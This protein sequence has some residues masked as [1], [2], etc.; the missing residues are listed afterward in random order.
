MRRKLDRRQFLET[1]GLTGLAALGGIACNRPGNPG[2]AASQA[3]PADSPARIAAGGPRAGLC[4][5]AFQERPLD[6]VI[7]LAAQAGF[8]GIEP[9]G[10]PDHLPLDTPDERVIAVREKVEGLGM[11][12]AHYGSYVRL[13]EQLDPEQQGRDM[14]RAVQITKLLGA[15]IIRIWAGSRNSEELIPEDWEQIVA[16]GKRFCALAEPANIILALEMHGNTLTNTAA[17]T[18]ELI[19]RVGS[20]VMRANYQPVAPEDPYERAR[21]VAPHVVMV[22]AQNWEQDGRSQAL[23]GQGIVDYRRIYEILQPAGFQGFFEAEFVKGDTFEQ[24][25]ES[26]RADAAFIHSL[27]A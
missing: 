4:T 10:K 17:A 24:K 1:V 20:P 6:E 12:V 18:L 16:D 11:I 2:E 26:A 23:I 9:W 15:P 7:E 14:A 19:E 22:H 8:D 3:V 25:V 21:L 5:I 27:G 13:G